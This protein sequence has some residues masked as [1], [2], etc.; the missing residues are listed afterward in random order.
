MLDNVDAIVTAT[1]ER[2]DGLDDRAWN[3]WRPLLMIATVAGGDWPHR[4]A[5]AA[6]ALA[7]DRDDDDQEDIGTLALQHVWEVVGPAGRLPTAD[8][9][10]HLVTKEEGPWA[11]WWETSI[12]KG[13][14]KSPAARLARLLKPFGVKPTQ[15]WIDGT[16]HRGYDAEHFEEATAA[17]YLEN[18]GRDGEDGRPESPSHAGSTVP[19]S[20]TDFLRAQRNG[21]PPPG[22]DPGYLTAIFAAFETGHITE[23]E[24]HT[25]NQLHRLL[26]LP[27]EKQHT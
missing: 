3:N 6:I 27:P 15:L 26:T 23:G 11:K 25:A 22:D 21:H 19:T 9:L 2:P 8:V 16:K 5:Q 4:A 12:E 7:A 1:V 14:L 18:Q 20:H 24:W 10:R 13:E 17:V